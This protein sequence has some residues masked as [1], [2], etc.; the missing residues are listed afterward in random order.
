MVKQK[1][2]KLLDGRNVLLQVLDPRVLR[3]APLSGTG[4]ELDDDGNLIAVNYAEEASFKVGNCVEFTKGDKYKIDKIIRSDA[5]DTPGYHL[6]IHSLTKS[7][8]LIMPFLG[9]QRHFFRWNKSF[10]NCFIGTESSGDY[11]ASIYLLYRWD[12]GKDFR[13]FESELI[14]HEWYTGSWEPDKY[15]TM[16]EFCIPDG[17]ED[18]NKIIKGKYS[19]VSVSGK[20]QIL[21]FHNADDESRLAKI[22]RRDE[23]LRREMSEDLIVDIPKDNELLSAFK[24]EEEMY[25]EK[26][27]IKDERRTEETGSQEIW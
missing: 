1:V 26:Y 2:L 16:Y 8:Q 22:L 24:V 12:S 7:S 18:I 5:A 20:E 23:K 3:I 6:F 13:G 4:E 9:A 15:H 19:H 21:N 17:H 27:S 11:G 10:C 14:S 25:L